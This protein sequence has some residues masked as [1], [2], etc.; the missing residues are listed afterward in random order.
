MIFYTYI[1][2]MN[3]S[4]EEKDRRFFDQNPDYV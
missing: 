2:Y 3:K 1:K 4:M